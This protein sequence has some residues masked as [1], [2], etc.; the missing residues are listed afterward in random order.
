MTKGEET[1][2]EKHWIY[3]WADE[4]SNALFAKNKFGFADGSIPIPEEGSPELLLWK[5]CNAMVRGWLHSSTDKE[6]RNNVKHAKTAC[7]VWE[8]L[9][10]RFGSESAPRAYELK[11]ILSLTRQEKMS[12]S[13]YYT[14]LK[15]LWDEIQAISPLP[16]CK[17]GGSSFHLVSEDER[18]K[19]IYATRKTSVEAATFQTQVAR[20]NDKN[21]RAP[22]KIGV[23]HCGKLYHS[24]EECYEIVGYPKQGERGGRNSGK[25]EDSRYKLRGANK[26]AHMAAGS[27]PLSGITIEQYSKLVEHFSKSGDTSQVAREENPT[28]A[29]MAGKINNLNSW[30]IDSGATEHITCDSMLLENQTS[31]G[32]EIPVKIPNGETVSVKSIGNANLPNGLKLNQ[33]LNIHAFKCNLLSVSKLTRNLNCALTFFPDFCVMQD[34]P[35]RNLIGMGRHCDGLY[36]LELTIK[37]GTALSVKVDSKT[38][39]KRLGHASS[40]KIQQLD[41]SF[42]SF[43]KNNE[44]CDSCLRAKLTRLPFPISSIQTASCFELIHCDIWGGYCTPSLSEYGAEGVIISDVNKKRQ[45]EWG[46]EDELLTGVGRSAM[47]DSNGSN[48]VDSTPMEDI[49]N[50]P[51]QV[52]ASDSQRDSEGTRKSDRI[53]YQPKRL[54]NYVTDLPKSIDHSQPIANSETSKLHVKVIWMPLSAFY[55]SSKQQRGKDFFFQQIRTS[56]L[57]HIVMLIG[58]LLHDKAFLYR[59]L[60]TI[61]SEILWLR[62]LLKDIEAIQTRATPLHCDNQA[63]CHIANNP[64]FHEQT[65]HVEMDCYFI[66]ERVESKDIEPRK[67]STYHQVADLFTKALGASRFRYLASMLGFRDLHA[68]T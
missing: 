16:K 55:D 15:G 62:W 36:L 65:K 53:K 29:N 63:A 35:S 61:V 5:R 49:R 18:Q 56:S 38:W 50:Q 17:C 4:I 26:S 13:A 42:G 60:A 9:Q 7:E 66:R 3:H 8:D 24:V 21:W 54:E 34:L 2:G 46:E 10:E 23:T 27:S 68:P 6:I 39:H 58:G 12:V 28:S 32:T 45:I 20:L 51:T 31:C 57:K 1:S 59:A 64:I 41:G 40:L 22:K 37:K 14:K 48:S 43:G 19:Q 52:V 30:I 11:H 44:H 47:D 67:I 33:V 25:K